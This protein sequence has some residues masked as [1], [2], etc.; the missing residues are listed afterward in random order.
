MWIGQRRA[1]RIPSRQ[2]HM[3]VPMAEYH[4][5]YQPVPT[6]SG[7]RF[8]GDGLV[9]QITTKSYR[10]VDQ[11]ALHGCVGLKRCSSQG[12]YAGG[13]RLGSAHRFPSGPSQ[14]GRDQGD[15]LYGSRHS[16][17]PVGGLHDGRDKRFRLLRSPEGEHLVL[18]EN[19]FVEVSLPSGILRKLSGEEME[20]YRA[21][22]RDRDRRLPT[23]IW[24]RELPIEGEPKDVV[25]MSM[26]TPNGWRRAAACRSFHQ[27]RPWS[28]HQ[29]ARARVLPDLAQSARD[30]GEGIA[31]PAG[32][33]AHG[34]R[35]SA[36]RIRA[37]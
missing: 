28:E 7:A 12:C 14:P 31:P 16:G 32:G 6:L 3:V 23:L 29:W 2:S 33:L 4:S 5:L 20:A 27:R 30:H 37:R 1:R 21:P 11:S 9:R 10:F 17:A 15:R 22:Y 36:A 18:D 35:C 26:T 8:R 19:M 13:A 34:D 25:A 24:P